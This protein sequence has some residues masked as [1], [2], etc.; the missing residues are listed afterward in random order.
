ML[1][2]I[3]QIHI[4]KTGSPC[5]SFRSQT[6]QQVGRRIIHFVWIT[7]TYTWCCCLILLQ[8]NSNLKKLSDE[9]QGIRTPNP[10]PFYRNKAYLLLGVIVLFLIG[11]YYTINGGHWAWADQKGTSQYSPFI[12]RIKYMPAPTR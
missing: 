7:Y 11:G 6:A 3:G 8:V 12:I 4:R 1:Y 2:L 5:R 9:K 10:V